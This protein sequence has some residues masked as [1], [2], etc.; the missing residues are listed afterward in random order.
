M[1]T[2]Q[3]L[4]VIGLAVIMTGA[5]GCSKSA[6]SATLFYGLSN[7]ENGVELKLNDVTIVI[8]GVDYEGGT[9]GQILVSKSHKIGGGKNDRSGGLEIQSDHGVATVI[10]QKGEGDSAT[11]LTFTI[12]DAVKR[13]RYG[14]DSYA[15][16]DGPKTIVIAEDGIASLQSSE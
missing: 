5:V 1:R 12:E 6:P 14:N 2:L 16:D 8:A 7:H 4:E 15:M 10:V 11:Y 3:F 13:L 9:Q